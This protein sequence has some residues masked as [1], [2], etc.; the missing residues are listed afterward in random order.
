MDSNV[1]ANIEELYKN[2]SLLKSNAVRNVGHRLT[3][4][5]SLTKSYNDWRNVLKTICCGVDVDETNVNNAA[6]IMDE[7]LQKM[8][9]YVAS[10]E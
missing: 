10:I 2:L 3:G 8:N 5:P 4:R 7:L 1:Q 6:S 9:S